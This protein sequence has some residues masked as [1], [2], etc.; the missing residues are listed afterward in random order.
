MSFSPLS[1]YSS[2]ATHDASAGCPGN[3]TRGSS[4][5]AT[6][7]HSRSRSN[8]TCSDCGS[9]DANTK[10]DDESEAKQPQPQQQ[11]T[12]EPGTCPGTPNTSS[13]ST[14]SSSGVGGQQSDPGAHYAFTLFSGLVQ[15]SITCSECATI[16]CKEEPI[17]DL[18]LDIQGSTG[19]HHSLRAFCADEVLEGD[20][21]YVFSLLSSPP[22]A[23]GSAGIWC[24]ARLPTLR[25]CELTTHSRTQTRTSSLSSSFLSLAVPAHP[26]LAR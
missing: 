20:N 13:H 17:E 18:Q 16:S 6:L 2:Y 24:S 4:T 26:H 9:A 11:P 14:G 21:A 7:P 23:P 19:F 10:P 5:D 25:R 12:T 15:N 1:S 3:R 22:P 8:S